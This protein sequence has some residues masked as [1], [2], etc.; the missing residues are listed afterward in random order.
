MSTYASNPAGLGVGKRYGPLLAGGVSGVY[1]GEGSEREIIWELAAKELPNGVP[2]TVALPANYLVESIYVEVETAFA[3]SSTVNLAIGGGV[4]LTTPISLATQAALASVAL[5]GLT[6]LSATTASS[7]V[8][9]A[10]A[11]A[12]AST[13]GKARIVVRYKA[14]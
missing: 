3:A 1:K 10:N 12:L 8:L 5:T 6:N 13:T 2:F 9:T 11:N 14:V 4:A 7:I